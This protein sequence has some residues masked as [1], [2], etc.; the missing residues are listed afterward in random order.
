MKNSYGGTALLGLLSAMERAQ[1]SYQKDGLLFSA[2]D[3][4]QDVWMVAEGL[5]K[6]RKEA[7]GQ[8]ERNASLRCQI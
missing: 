4:V 5:F 7:R 8:R 3:G 6:A 1:Y 2:T